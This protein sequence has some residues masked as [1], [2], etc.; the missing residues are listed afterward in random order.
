MKVLFLLIVITIILL[1]MGEVKA[2]DVI[3]SNNRELVFKSSNGKPACVFSDS[4][5]KLMERGWA[6][7]YPDKI[8]LKDGRISIFPEDIIPYLWKIELEKRDIDYQAADISYTNID[9]EPEPPWR[10]CSPLV[11]SN[12]TDFYISAIIEENPSKVS[13]VFLDRTQPIDCQKIWKIKKG[14]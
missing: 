14:D 7:L 8:Y 12:G 2:L 13:D 1:S 4:I 10:A 3:C 9:V 5:S 6:I 11:A